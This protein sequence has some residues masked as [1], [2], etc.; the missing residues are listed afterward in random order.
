MALDGSYVTTIALP[1]RKIGPR[2]IRQ[3]GTWRVENGFLIDA[4][5]K[6]SQT[7]AA[8]PN[9]SRFRII[10]IDDRELELD[11]QE[12]APGAVYPTNQVIYRRQTE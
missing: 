6:D 2:T 9:S 1:S 10:R 4:V 7:N 12:K 11:D 3:E 5:L 8:V